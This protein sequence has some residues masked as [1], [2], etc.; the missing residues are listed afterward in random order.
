MSE[1]EEKN[2]HI[3]NVCIECGSPRNQQYRI[4]FAHACQPAGSNVTMCGSA[5]SDGAQILNVKCGVRIK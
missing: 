5:H 4:P 3:A 2:T 1:K